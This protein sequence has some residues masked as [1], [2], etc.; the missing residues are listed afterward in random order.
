MCLTTKRRSP[1]TRTVG[2]Y[3]LPDCLANEEDLRRVLHRDVPDLPDAALF[4]ETT[5]VRLAFARAEGK[6]LVMPGPRVC[7]LLDVAA[8]LYDRLRVLLTEERRRK[9]SAR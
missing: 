1:F 4:A 8:W 2:G 9:G 7:D 3:D 6:H 5:A